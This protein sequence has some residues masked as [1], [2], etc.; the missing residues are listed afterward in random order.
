MK[1]S[2]AKNKGREGQKE[3]IAMALEEL[4][5][6]HED[7][8]RCRSMGSG[9]EDVMMSPLAKSIIPFDVEVKRCQ[10]MSIW[11]V[12]KQ[13]AAN[14]TGPDRSW[15][16][17]FRRNH[18]QWNACIPLRSLLVLIRKAAMWDSFLAKEQR[19]NQRPIQ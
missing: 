1:P 9:G 5:M 15:M 2:S 19:D 7:D 12:I 8:L 6:L 4:P 14:L 10:S 3:V 11:A 17:A 18:G 16:V 13:A